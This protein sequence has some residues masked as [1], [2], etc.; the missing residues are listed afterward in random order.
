MDEQ[1]PAASDAAIVLIVDDESLGREMLA[2]LLQ[3]LGYQLLFAGSGPDALAQAAACPPDLILLD[4]MMP[5]MDGFEVCQRV[6]ADPLLGDVPVVMLT[7]LDDRGSRLRAL[8]TGADDFVSK[9]FD[10]IELRARVR[11]ITRLNRYRRLLAER[12]RLARMIELAPDG[13]LIVDDSGSIV[14]ANPAMLRLLGAPQEADLLGRPMIGFV[15]LEQR[16]ECRARLRAAMAE[17]AAVVRFESMLVR[18]DGT[19]LP[20]EMH[21][22]N[23]AWAGQPAVQIIARDIT[24]RKRAELLEEERHQIAYELHDGLAQIVTSAHQHLQAY[25]G[26]HRPRRTPAR[27]QLDQALELARRAVQEVRRVIAGLRPTALDDFGLAVALQMHVESLRADGWEID[28]QSTLGAERLPPAIETVIFRVAM[29]ALTN[30]RKH[31]AT[32]RA[33]VDLRREGPSLCLQ[34][35]DWGRG[36]DPAA[37]IGGASLG[38]RI[39]LRGMRERIELLGGQWSIESR[40]GG[41]RIV[42]IVPLSP[43]KEV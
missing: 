34:V 26:N 24:E 43:L 22:G 9:P 38:E 14:L 39:G 5:G 8:D 15:V 29:E 10:R 4:V 30:I 41:T 16:D 21:A 11:T 33:L 6:R 7:A 28:Y 20:L 18:Q 42:A 12:A 3:P 32:T 36:F 31:A 40:P 13:V 27:Q 2:A 37:L 23:F 17:P 1:I 19:R 25:A 35:Q